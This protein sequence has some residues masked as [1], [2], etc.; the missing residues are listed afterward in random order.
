MPLHYTTSGVE[1]K[2]I[3]SETSGLFVSYNWPGDVGGEVGAFEHGTFELISC[4]IKYAHPPLFNNTYPSVTTY[5][6]PYNKMVNLISV[7][8]F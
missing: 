4:K 3:L 1:N 5:V 2:R 8:R 6:K 7:N